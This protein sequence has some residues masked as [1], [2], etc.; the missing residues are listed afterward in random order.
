MYPV[1]RLDMY[2]EGLLILT[3]DGEAA[4]ALMH[5]SHDAPRRYVVD[6]LGAELGR[7]AEVMA[8]QTEVDGRPCARL[9]CASLPARRAA[10]SW[11]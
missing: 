9:R 10:G 6:V 5:P 3:D 4:N 11:K 7:A 2:S 8:A 1:G